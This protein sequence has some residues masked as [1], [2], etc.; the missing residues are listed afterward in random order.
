[1]IEYEGLKIE[2]CKDVYTPAEDSFLFADNLKLK[3]EDNV[4]EIGPGTGIISITASKTV[5][6]V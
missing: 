4:L 5:K 6:K 2:T 1:M 3:P